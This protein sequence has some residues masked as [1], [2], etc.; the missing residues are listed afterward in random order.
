MTWIPASWLLR[1]QVAI[2]PYTSVWWGKGLKTKVQ[3]SKDG[4]C[5]LMRC[6]DRDWSISIS[7]P[8]LQL[9]LC[10]QKLRLILPRLNGAGMGRLSD[11]ELQ[12]LLKANDG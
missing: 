12:E 8:A 10:I 2:L 1:V 9:G 3:R 5:V 6:P 11:D 4:Y 7:G